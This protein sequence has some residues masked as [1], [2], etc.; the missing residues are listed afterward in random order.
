MYYHVEGIKLETSRLKLCRFEKK[1]SS[2][3]ST[4]YPNRSPTQIIN[5]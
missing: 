3:F 4:N 2:F 1:L 5:K